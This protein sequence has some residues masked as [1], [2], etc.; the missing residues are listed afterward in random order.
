ML[1]RTSSTLMESSFAQTGAPASA[2]MI[3]AP[4]IASWNGDADPYELAPS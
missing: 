3:A 1:V 2:D 4:W